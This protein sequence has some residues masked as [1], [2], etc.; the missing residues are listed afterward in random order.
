MEEETKQILGTIETF[1]KRIDER[2]ERIEAA[3]K[4]DDAKYL[5]QL[6][7]RLEQKFRD[8]GFVDYSR[9]APCDSEVEPDGCDAV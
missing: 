2:L 6:K 8:G 1:V 3:V 5:D 9:F 4:P 7:R